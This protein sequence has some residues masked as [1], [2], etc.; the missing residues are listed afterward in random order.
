MHRSDS[1]FLFDQI[2]EDLAALPGVT[3]IASAMDHSLQTAIRVFLL[4]SRVSKR[5]RATIRPCFN[6]IGAGFFGTVG[7]SLMSGRDFST[8]DTVNR[9]PVAIVNERFAERFGLGRDA[10]GKRIGLGFREEA[11]TEIIGVVRDSKYSTVKDPVPAQLFLPRRQA[12]FP[13]ND[14]TFY[15]RSAGRIRLSC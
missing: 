10:I 11:D 4:V 7:V 8:A 9:P 5:R 3:A 12:P 1:A 15:V 14:L 6:M 13:I 2:E